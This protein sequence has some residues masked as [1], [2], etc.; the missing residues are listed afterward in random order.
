[1]V[2]IKLGMISVRGVCFITRTQFHDPR[3]FHIPD[4]TGYL[5]GNQK[6]TTPVEAKLPDD[7]NQASLPPAAADDDD[8]DDDYVDVNNDVFVHRHHSVA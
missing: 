3:T 8:D 4:Q 2:V 7:Y 5:V 1:M 6:L